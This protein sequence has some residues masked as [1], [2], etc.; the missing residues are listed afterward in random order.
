MSQHVGPTERSLWPRSRTHIMRSPK[1]NA[2][3]ISIGKLKGAREMGRVWD[4]I[5]PE[6]DLSV[7][8]TA[9][10]GGKSGFGRWPALLIVDILYNFVGERP[11]PISESVKEYP[12]SCGEAGW[13]AVYKTKELLEAARAASIPIFYGQSKPKPDQPPQ[14]NPWAARGGPTDVDRT[15]GRGQDIVDELA[16]QPGEMIIDK[17][18]RPSMFF[19]TAL[20]A[21]LTSL[22][23]DTVLVCGCTTSGCVRATVVDAFSYSYKTIVVEE[24][25]FDR[26]AVS[27]KVNLFDMHQKY[28]DVLPLADVEAYLR[29]L[30]SESRQE[31]RG[32]TR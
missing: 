15:R 10:Y 26:S 13:Q 2:I 27:H 8:A 22:R 32:L 4:D 3:L 12:N 5:I 24:C 14:L 19:G 7:Y 18:F 1:E 17:N 29:T 30:R 20:A 23:V 31:V 21:Y 6:N 28:A 16:P 9:G 11:E 25:T